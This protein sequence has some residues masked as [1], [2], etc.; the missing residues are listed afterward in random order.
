MAPATASSSPPL[1]QT[2]GGA[3]GPSKGRPARQGSAGRPTRVSPCPG[4][5]PGGHRRV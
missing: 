2:P 3:A 5:Q 4:A 1:Q